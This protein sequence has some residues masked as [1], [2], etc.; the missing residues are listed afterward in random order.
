[1]AAADLSRRQ[2]LFLL[3]QDCDDLLLGKPALLHRPTP[4]IEAV[5]LYSFLDQFAGLTPSVT[6]APSGTSG[7]DNICFERLRRSKIPPLN[8]S[9]LTTM[10]APTW[11]SE[12]LHRLRS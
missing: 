4:L 1:M 2:P 5:G 12:A 8:G 9:G 6:I 3:P 10:S 7:S 11:R